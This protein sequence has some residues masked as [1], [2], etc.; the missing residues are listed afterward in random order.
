[1]IGV[2]AY[3]TYKPLSRIS[4][5][6]RLKDQEDCGTRSSEELSN[7]VD[8][9]DPSKKDLEELNGYL[10][11]LK[12]M[13]ISFTVPKFLTKDKVDEINSLIDDSIWE[14]DS[15]IEDLKDGTIASETSYS[16][17]GIP[18]NAD[19]SSFRAEI[20]NRAIKNKWD[21]DEQII[22]LTRKHF[23]GAEIK[24]LPGI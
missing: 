19:F 5:Y 3:L 4:K 20:I 8:S 14:A 12:K 7:F 16:V 11:K 13:K 17:Q 2:G 22:E 15:A 23:P 18:D 21:Y 6:N 10:S 1:M 9:E 24:K